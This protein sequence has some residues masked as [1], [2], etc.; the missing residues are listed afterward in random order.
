MADPHSIIKLVE[1]CN[2]QMISIHCPIHSKSAEV[3]VAKWQTQDGST[4]PWI[5]VDCPLLP[6]GIIDCDMSCLAKLDS[7]AADPG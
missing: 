7:R 2:S 5:V 3:T 1:S 6:A 4:T